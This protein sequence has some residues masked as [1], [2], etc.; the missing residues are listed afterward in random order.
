MPLP[1][2]VIENYRMNVGILNAI[3]GKTPE[4]IFAAVPTEGMKPA[5][6]QLGHIIYSLAGAA[7]ILGKPVELSMDYAAKYGMGTPPPDADATYESME[8]MS[9][10]LDTAIKAVDNAITTVDDARLA[11][12]EPNAMMQQA[13]ITTIGSMATFL[14][15]GHLTYH[16]GYLASCRRAHGEPSALGF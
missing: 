10:D 15:T 11:E 16:V 7:A 8:T 4:S 3:L 13:G 14:T 12:P 9:K 2:P 1:T 6:W 5:A